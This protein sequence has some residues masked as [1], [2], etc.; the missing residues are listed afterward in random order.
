MG[1]HVLGLILLIS[2][3]SLA[4]G[5]T[6]TTQNG[7]IRGEK[8]SNFFAFK[9]IQY[10][11]SPVGMKRF[12][13]VEIFSEK[14]TEVRNAT[15]FANP[16]L[17]WREGSSDQLNGDEDC[18]FLNVYTSHIG[19]EEN[20]PVFVHFHG[21]GFTYG[22]GTFFSP[23]R[24]FHRHKL[25]FVTVNYRLGPLGFLSTEDEVVPGNMGLKD[26]VVALLWVKQNIRFFGGNPNSVTLSGFSA[27]G[28]SV[29]LHYLSP[30]SSGLFHRGIS[31]SGCALNPW[32]LAENPLQK[33]RVVANHLGC[34]TEDNRRM[35]ECLKGKPADEIVSTVP[36]F[37]PWLSQPFTPFGVVVEK[38]SE[39]PFLSAH[40]ELIYKSQAFAHLPWI[41]SYTDADGIYP[42]A[43]LLLDSTSLT[44]LRDRWLEL[45]PFLLDFNETVSPETSHDVSNQILRHYLSDKQ[46]SRDSFDDIVKMLTDRMFAADIARSVRLH[47]QHSPTFLYFL[48]FPAVFGVGHIILGQDTTFN[49]A[50]HGDDV[51]MLLKNRNDPRVNQ[52]SEEKEICR[53]LTEIYMS[54]ASD[55]QPKLDDLAFEDIKSRELFS[56]LNIKTPSDFSMDKSLNVGEEE[57]WRSLPLREYKTSAQQLPT[58]KGEL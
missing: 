30:L 34:A 56:F 6:V 4:Q 38:N 48:Q 21:G 17:Q 12:E 42:A 7:P 5:A 29:H 44:E 10:G 47:S 49:G 41:V 25:V 19:E 50:A 23:E 15:Q 18:L 51:F 45:A 27:G 13:P 46:I 3:V 2:G 33:A 24:M 40:P 58:Q 20:L 37:Q 39:N 31:H 14:W 8:H 11:E 55:S 36:L 26:Q 53:L 28:A 52:T 22:S 1:N 43:K 32:V 35:I 54:F 57:F 9:G 16:C